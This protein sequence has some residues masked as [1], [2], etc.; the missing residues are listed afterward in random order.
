MQIRRVSLLLALATFA[1]VPAACG[2][3]DGAPPSPDA[4]A[5]DSGGGAINAAALDAAADHPASDATADSGAAGDGG[6]AQVCWRPIARLMTPEE[7]ETQE[8]VSQECRCP[9]GFACSGSLTTKAGVP[10]RTGLGGYH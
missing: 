6:C 1:L 5:N 7:G 8:F 10:T 3:D 2:D 4:A 9:D